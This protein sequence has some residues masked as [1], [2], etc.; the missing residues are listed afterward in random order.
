M[1][2]RTAIV[3]SYCGGPTRIEYVSMKTLQ[4]QYV[5][6][7]QTNEGLLRGWKKAIQTDDLPPAYH[8]SG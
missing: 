8:G 6:L 5:H 1:W 2:Y 7:F 4:V 3:E